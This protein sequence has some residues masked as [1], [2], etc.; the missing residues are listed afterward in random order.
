MGPEVLSV[1]EMY[2]A[3][4]LAVAGGVT[5]EQLMEAAGHAVAREVRRRFPPCRVAILCGPGNNGGDG[6]VAARLLERAG[7]PVRLALL[8]DVVN[9]K[10][11]AARMAG[12][13]RGRVEPLTPA[14]LDGAGVVVDALFGA[15]LARPPGG[16]AAEVI[17]ELGLLLLPVIAVDV[18]SGVDGDTGAIL[19]DAP[20][21]VATVTFFRKKPG[22]LL[23]PGRLKCGEVVV[24]DIGIPDTVLAEVEPPVA[25]NAPSLW[26]KAFPWP[27]ADGHKYARGHVVVVGGAAMTG[28]ARLAARAA[29]R[30]GAGLA[31]IAAPPE[32]LAVYR[33]G[34]PGTI[35]VSLD[36]YAALLGD[37]RKNA[38]VLG[39]GG[40]TGEPMRARVLA[41]LKA[42]KA[43]VLDADALTSFADAPRE[44]FKA[45]S[46]NAVLT[47]HDGEFARLFGK[48]GG[49]RLE[50]ARQAAGRAGAV[51]LL[52]GADT[53]VAH[54]DGRA[55][56]NANAPPF[57]AT[58]GSGDVLAGLIGGLL[59][60]G[61]DAFDGAACG[62]W[63]HGAAAASVGPGL[64]AEDLA[65]ALPRVLAHLH[66]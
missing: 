57:L 25:E 22:H 50:R 45:L 56:I 26:A 20:D 11:D 65:D 39:P 61:M 47:P 12:R 9:L 2:R 42:G 16:A 8:G 31:T 7:Y 33:A 38:V 43:A 60:A 21:A 13:W 55:V 19:G 54:P 14:V 52:K 24:A 40:G 28:A 10:G 64:I 34:D 17:A 30:V 49:S 59:A 48:A 58:A 32:A 35:V 51:V 46:A 1:A 66:P 29:R 23:L 27:R 41:A 63:L 15:G 3:D 18:P 62:V 5:G 44:L 4:A 53:V 6:F 37:P 36:D